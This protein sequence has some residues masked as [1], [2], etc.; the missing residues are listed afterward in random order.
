V[1]LIVL[2]VFFVAFV[3]ILLLTVFRSVVE[4]EMER[5][6]VRQENFAA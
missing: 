2:S 4:G 1:I 3:N 6:K 5:E